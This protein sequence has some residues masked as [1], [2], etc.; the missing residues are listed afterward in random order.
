MLPQIGWKSIAAN[1]ANKNQKENAG[2][3]KLAH[4]P[5]A[6]RSLKG[7]APAEPKKDQIFPQAT[8]KLENRKKDSDDEGFDMDF[9]D[10]ELPVKKKPEPKNVPVV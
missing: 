4:L 3:N 2:S 9:F 10:D 8:K 1:D 7:V 6:K 5:E